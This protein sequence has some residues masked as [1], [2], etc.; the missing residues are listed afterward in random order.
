MNPK[1]CQRYVFD[2]TCSYGEKCNCLHKEKEQSPAELK[3]KEKNDE[4]EKLKSHQK[5]KKM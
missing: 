4:L 3:F 5:K 1:L 2:K